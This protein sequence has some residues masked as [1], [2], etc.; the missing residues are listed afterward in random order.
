MRGAGAVAHDDER[1]R[2]TQRELRIGVADELPPRRGELLGV[3]ADDLDERAIE[4]R[5]TGTARRLA[6]AAAPEIG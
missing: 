2:G 4:D 3:E 1:C 5:R 6:P